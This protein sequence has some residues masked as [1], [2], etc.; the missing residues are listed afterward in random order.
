MQTENKDHNST[1]IMWL[2]QEMAHK[3]H[4]YAQT[5]LENQGRN[6]WLNTS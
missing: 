3:R 1:S 4:S 2:C 6:T 5:S